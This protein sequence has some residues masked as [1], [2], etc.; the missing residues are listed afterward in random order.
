MIKCSLSL[1]LV[2]NR[3]PK[4]VEKKVAM[5]KI[6]GSAKEQDAEYYEHYGYM[7]RKKKSYMEAA[8]N[9][10]TALKLDP[11]KTDLIKKIEKYVYSNTPYSY[12]PYH[13]HVETVRK[14]FIVISIE[15]KS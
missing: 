3:P 1:N 2:A 6:I 13:L 12:Q 10:E 8:A 15:T 9:W 14:I 4:K 5:E 11:S 7:L